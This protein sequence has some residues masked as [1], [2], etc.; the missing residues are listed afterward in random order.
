[1]V[2]CQGLFCPGEK[3]GPV[4]VAQLVLAC[5]ALVLAGEVF[6]NAVEWLGVRLALTRS[7]AGAIVAA[8]GSS[9]PETIIAAVALLVLHDTRSTQIG[10]GAVLGAPFMLSTL[11]FFLIGVLA[12]LRS[13]R[14]ALRGIAAPAGPALVG[15]ALFCATFA[16]ALGASLAPARGVHV[17]AAVAVLAAYVGYVLYHV[18]ADPAGAQTP[19]PPLHLS[20]RSA[21]PA[22]W[23][24]LVQF[25]LALA[26]TV[27]AS[28]W[29]V[30]VVGNAALALGAAPFLVSVFIS[31]IATE[32]PEAT[33]VWLWMR[34]GEDALA[35]SNVLGAMMFQTSFACA[36]AMLATPW[37]LDSAAYASAAATL[38]G[39]GW[40]LL[41]TAVRGR[42]E[43]WILVC[44]ILPYLAYAAWSA[45]L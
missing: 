24:V 26:L 45:R 23:I 7:A 32:L 20:R 17:A 2:D 1:V 3:T 40:V 38:L 30:L 18:R 34:R 16:L 13:P 33:N 25:G 21:V 27:A 9:L 39:A 19:P 36:L 4:I 29:F 44:A 35:V 43:P 14:R 42:L 15:L 10:I 28:R 31:P 22:T 11:V 6:T 8:A 12:L 5:A 41:W 37:R